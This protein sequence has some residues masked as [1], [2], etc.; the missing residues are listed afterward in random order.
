MPVSFGIILILTI[1]S[2]NNLNNNKT[3]LQPG[4]VVELEKKDNENKSLT[5]K[6]EI[7]INEVG[8]SSNSGSDDEDKKNKTSNHEKPDKSQSNKLKEKNLKTD[9]FDASNIETENNDPKKLVDDSDGSNNNDPIIN[10]PDNIQKTEID[11]NQPQ[12]LDTSK[13]YYGLCTECSK[14]EIKDIK[15]ISSFAYHN[16][17][18]NWFISSANSYVLLD[19][20][21]SRLKVDV[22]H[23]TQTIETFN[24]GKVGFHTIKV[25]ALNYYGNRITNDFVEVYWQINEW[26]SNNQVLG[27]FN[28]NDAEL[29]RNLIFEYRETLFNSDNTRNNGQGFLGRADYIAKEALLPKNGA[30]SYDYDNDEIIV[31]SDNSAEAVFNSIINNE[32]QKKLI[33]TRYIYDIAASVFKGVNGVKAWVLFFR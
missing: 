26:E 24:N 29:L 23:L 20:Y 14:N 32:T 4:A 19:Q 10:K 30:R 31:Y 33:E 12:I 7:V 17:N 3:G 11:K 9:D 1:A 21:G 18:V 13:S 15:T 28:R 6:N 2:N 22:D 16:I 5:N 27:D 25:Y 8:Q